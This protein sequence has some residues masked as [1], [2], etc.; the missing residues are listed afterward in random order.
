MIDYNKSTTQL[1][2]DM[3][4]DRLGT[5]LRIKDVQ[6]TEF[7]LYP[8]GYNTSVKIIPQPGSGWQESATIRYNRIDIGKLFHGINVTVKPGYQQLLSDYLPIINSDYNLS[9]MP[10]DIV[11]GK[12]PERIQ[13]PFKL[14]IVMREDNPAF[15]GT[16]SI[17]VTDS[18]RSIADIFEDI[19]EFDG[20]AYPVTNNEKLQG[21]LYFFNEDWTPLAKIL[22]GY[23]VGDFVDDGLVIKLNKVSRDVWVN[24][25]KLD[26]FNLH[27]ATI[28]FNGP[29]GIDNPYTSKR[30]PDNVLVIGINPLYCSNV[31]GYLVLHY[32]KKFTLPI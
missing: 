18:K 6:L 3:I 14:D 28:I 25:P 26:V 15:I 7:A 27:Q 30:Q 31:E 5:Q 9:L 16:L 2:L 10:E 32:N 22:E 11:D 8:S 20:I 12:I 4:N 1:A 19:N 17:L 21:P 23:R 29:I 13:P 24:Q